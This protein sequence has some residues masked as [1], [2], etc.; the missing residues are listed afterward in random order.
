MRAQRSCARH[1]AAKTVRR[2]GGAAPAADSS[3]APSTSPGRCAEVG[4]DRRLARRSSIDPAGAVRHSLRSVPG[5]RARRSP[6]A[7]RRPL[8]PRWIADRSRD[9]DRGADGQDAKLDDDGADTRRSPPTPV[10][11]G[12]MGSRRAQATPARAAAGGRARGGGTAG[13]GGGADRPRPRRADGSAETALSIMGGDRCPAPR[14]PRWAADRRRAGENPRRSRRVGDA[15]PCS[16]G[17]P[18]EAA[19]LPAENVPLE[20]STTGSGIFAAMGAALIPL[21]VAHASS[22]MFSGARSARSPPTG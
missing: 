17:C 7:G 2:R 12:A 11:I 21:A 8:S 4:A 1:G 9:R 13:P 14:P 15:I 10:Y 20:A 3:S 19:L 6:A 18:A 16:P 22:G 5:G